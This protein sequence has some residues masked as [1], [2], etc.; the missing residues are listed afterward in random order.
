MGQVS[1]HGKHHCPLQ[2]ADGSSVSDEHN[3]LQC[4]S[5]YQ[6]SY[7]QQALAHTELQPSPPPPPVCSAVR[8]AGGLTLC[9][10]PLSRQSCFP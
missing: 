10:A 8:G 7:S 6:D 5:I 2:C 9:S 3:L 1:L 4:G